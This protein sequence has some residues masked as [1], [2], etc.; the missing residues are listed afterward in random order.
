[1]A[2]KQKRFN[3][4]KYPIIEEKKLHPKYYFIVQYKNNISIG[5]KSDIGEFTYINA[6]FGVEIGDYVQIGSH[7]S[8]YSISTI[9]N[10]EGKVILE[11]NC[12][13]GAHSMIM[14]GITIGENAI[15]GAFSFVNINIPKN[16]LAYGIP[17]KIIRK[18]TSDEIN[19]LIGE[20]E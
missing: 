4:W 16:V 15:I 6:K 20:M 11:K 2:N 18:L 19:N 10:K 5:Y 17:V 13:I 7:C 14:P 12:R 1:M 8:I 3:E 9:D